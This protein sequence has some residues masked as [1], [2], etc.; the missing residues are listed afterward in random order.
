MTT[1]R[2][3]E[4]TVKDCLDNEVCF[5]HL[6]RRWNPNMKEYILTTKNKTHII[7]VSKTIEKLKEACKFID[8]VV[9]NGGKILFVCTK[10]QF[11]KYIENVAQELK[12]P[13]VTEKWFGGI[14]TNIVTVR[15][16]I[17]RVENVNKLIDSPSFKF[18]TK[19]ERLVIQRNLN[20]K[21]KILDG[22]FGMYRLPEA[23][24]IID[25]KKDLI[26][27]QEALQ[28]NIPIISIVDTNTDPSLVDYPIPA[29]DDSLKSIKLITEQVKG[30]ILEALTKKAEN[31]TVTDIEKTN[32]KEKVTDAKQKQTSS[33]KSTPTN[34]IKA[35]AV[36]SNTKTKP[37]KKK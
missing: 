29:N 18:L 33:K 12:M 31:K 36:N 6:A 10:K 35:T 22:V 15:K 34:G 11:K 9:A 26:A 3:T 5:G 27:V 21:K 7:D 17:K 14:L 1:E 16:M 23:L 8:S 32:V 19:K 20:K 13:Y 28:R 37:N 25:I 24:F 30:C 4:L 2:K